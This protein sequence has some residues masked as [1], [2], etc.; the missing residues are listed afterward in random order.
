MTGSGAR[1]QVET[2]MRKLQQ[3][4]AVYDQHSRAVDSFSIVLWADL[5][6]SK[7]VAAAEEVAT[8]LKHM[9]HLADQP[10]YEAVCSNIHGFMSSLP[11]MQELKS[12]ALR[13]RH[14]NALMKVRGVSTL[15]IPGPQ[16]CCIINS[17]QLV[18]LI[19]DLNMMLNICD[20]CTQIVTC[21]PKSNRCSMS[22]P[23]N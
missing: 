22:V 20:M 17:Q 14:W 4:Y 18:R 19:L 23:Q 15:G 13:K 16:C 10:I 7:I 5:D 6:V 3:I 2:E 12:D 1:V 21:A 11:L 8:K 9:K